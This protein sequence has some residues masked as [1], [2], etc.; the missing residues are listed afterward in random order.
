MNKF[1]KRYKKRERF[2]RSPE[3]KISLLALVF[4][5]FA[6][7]VVKMVGGVIHTVG[8]HEVGELKSQRACDTC[9]F[10]FFE[11][12][13]QFFP[14][15]GEKTDGHIAV[16]G[17]AVGPEFNAVFVSQTLVEGH[18]GTEFLIGDVTILERDD[19]HIT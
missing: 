13:A 12:V 9:F 10:S 2:C 3:K 7:A 16:K 15:D 4:E 11:L 17:F 19:I 14:F 1:H 18:G 6:V 5:I 8:T